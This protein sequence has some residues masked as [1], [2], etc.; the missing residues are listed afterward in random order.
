MAITVTRNFPSLTSSALLTKD[1]WDGVGQL[2]RQRIIQRTE[3]GVDAQGAPF[4]PYNPDYALQKGRELL[5]AEAS[6]SKVD[7]TI[8]GE[9]LQAISYES[10]DKG[11][12]LF[13]NR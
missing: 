8:S 5:G 2:I 11:V 7:L 9:M 3:A 6:Y 10:T 13:F 1:D 4:A 12:T